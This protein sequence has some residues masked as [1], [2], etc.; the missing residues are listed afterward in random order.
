MDQAKYRVCRWRML[1][2]FLLCVS[3]GLAAYH[4]AP[5]FRRP[6]KLYF[7]AGVMALVAPFALW[8]VVMATDLTFD[9]RGI[10]YKRRSVR[11]S[12]VRNI[13]VEL[14][15]TDT[16]MG[17]VPTWS[18][19][20]SHVGD[21]HVKQRHT[22]VAYPGLIIPSTTRNDLIKID[23]SRATLR[24]NSRSLYL[25]RG[26]LIE[27]AQRM[28]DLQT[29]ILGEGGGARARL[30]LEQHEPPSSEPPPAPQP[31]RPSFGRKGL[32]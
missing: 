6:S 25:P 12:E 14:Q 17:L 1:V 13:S 19:Q 29:K 23:T 21:V 28:I 2:L 20:D 5:E 22:S 32:A 8:E 24:I 26:G 11:W 18:S 15:D 9:S 4:V 10:R 31:A 27:I 7:F 30:G 16:R 3:F